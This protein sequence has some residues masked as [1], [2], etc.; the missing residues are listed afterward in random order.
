MLPL[1]L[2]DWRRQRKRQDSYGRPQ[3]HNLYSIPEISSI[4]LQFLNNCWNTQEF[5]IICKHVFICIHSQTAIY[6]GDIPEHYTLLQFDSIHGINSLHKSRKVIHPIHVV[7]FC[8][9]RTILLL[10]YSWK[11]RVTVTTLRHLAASRKAVLTLTLLWS[12]TFCLQSR[13]RRT[14]QQIKRRQTSAVVAV[15]HEKNTTSPGGKS[16]HVD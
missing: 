12:K 16:E 2:L 15:K 9:R 14:V 3:S 8:S 5:Y 4:L 1:N 10:C 11:V 7:S 13:H 6:N